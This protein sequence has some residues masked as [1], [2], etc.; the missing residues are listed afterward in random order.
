[1]STHSLKFSHTKVAVASVLVLFLLF[2][3]H[4]LLVEWRKPDAGGA[5]FWLGCML[6]LFAILG[7]L[8]YV[9]LTGMKVKNPRPVFVEPPLW[10]AAPVI[11]VSMTVSVFAFFILLGIVMVVDP[12][13]EQA[14]VDA[15]SFIG[16]A[17]MAFGL[18]TSFFAPV[19][20]YSIAIKMRYVKVIEYGT[21][22]WKKIRGK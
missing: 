1:M 5:G 17:V 12:R 7:S 15:N 9:H 10:K 13:V 4:K 6:A 18:V 16:N 20:I 8:Y 14:I 19:I 11:L 22:E 3:V 2:Q 21:P